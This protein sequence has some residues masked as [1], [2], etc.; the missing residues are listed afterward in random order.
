MSVAN[1]AATAVDLDI[2]A[3]C[4][5]IRRKVIPEILKL[6]PTPPLLPTR[7]PISPLVTADF[8]IP[9]MTVRI[10]RI[11][12][13]ATSRTLHKWQQVAIDKDSHIDT[14]QALLNEKFIWSSLL[15]AYRMAAILPLPELLNVLRDFRSEMVLLLLFMLALVQILIMTGSMAVVITSLAHAPTIV[16]L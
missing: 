15:N 16:I 1:Y 3:K 5:L 12:R 9:K 13:K 7:P 10:R 11:M 14:H 8:D 6:T 4:A 2:P